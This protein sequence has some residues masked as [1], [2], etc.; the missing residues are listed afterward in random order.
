MIEE[1]GAEK[2]STER[3]SDIEPLLQDR[4]ATTSDA[5][6][7]TKVGSTRSFYSIMLRRGQTYAAIFNVVAFAMILSGFDATLPIHLRDSF[8]WSPGPIGSIFLGLQIPAMFLAPFVGWLR[9]RIGLRWPTTIGWALCAPLLWFTGVPGDDDFLGVGSGTRGQAAFVASIIGV[10]ITSAFV[11]GA[12]T[13]Q[14]TSILHELKEQDPMI[15]GPGGGSSRMF[16]LTEM[17]FAVGLLLGPLICG[18]LA[19]SV[20]FYWTACALATAAGIVATTSFI[21]FTHK[22]PILEL[23]D[24][25]EEA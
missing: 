5:T 21:F 8:G 6:N 19:E 13:F 17:S 7:E 22:A 25:E 18:A 2:A 10:G 16:S 11:R 14:L 20:G 23:F 3:A 4:E 15:F 1:R 24:D 9:D 12:G